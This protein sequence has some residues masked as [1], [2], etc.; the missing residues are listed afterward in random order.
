[1][2]DTICAETMI[3]DPYCTDEMVRLRTQRYASVCVDEKC[4]LSGGYAHVG[5]CEPC[6]CGMEHA[7]A[8]CP[9]RP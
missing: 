3:G 8:E 1:M 4:S 5:P 2:T 7:I 9:D 6:K